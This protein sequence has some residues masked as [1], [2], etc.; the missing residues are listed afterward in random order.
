VYDARR[1]A[2]QSV[3]FAERGRASFKILGTR[4][5]GRGR[6]RFTPAVGP[7]GT[8]HIVAI[9]TLDGTPIPEQTLASYQAPG[10]VK[11]GRP[12]RVQVRRKGTAL[13]V[14][15]GAAPGAARYGVVLRLSNGSMRIFKA[16]ARR[17]SLRISRV[18]LDQ[19]GTVEVSAQGVL[20]DW[21][22]PSSAGFR[23]LRQPFTVLQTKTSNERRGG[24]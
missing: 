9:P 19:S 23:R 17:R 21:G 13:S 24:K 15:W 6:I 4:N 11:A 5:G 20:N 22:R 7:A 14:S 16:A 2:G 8:R 18:A 10:V 1:K 12:R 3:T